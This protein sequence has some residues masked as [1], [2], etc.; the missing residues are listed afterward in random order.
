MAYESDT[1]AAMQWV[2]ENKD[3]YN[4]RV[5]NLSLNSTLQQSYHDSPLDL[6]SELLWFNGIVVVASAGNRSLDGNFYTITA[7]PGQRPFNHHRGC[8]Y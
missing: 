3:V 2:L 5:V 1:V 7:S 8:Q 6:A 4:I